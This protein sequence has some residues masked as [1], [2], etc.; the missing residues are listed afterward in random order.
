MGRRH[1]D[2]D[3]GGKAYEAGTLKPRPREQEGPVT[4]MGG[5]APRPATPLLHAQKEERQRAGCTAA[6]GPSSLALPAC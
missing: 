1:L 6:Q 4:E 3:A 5:R 2:R